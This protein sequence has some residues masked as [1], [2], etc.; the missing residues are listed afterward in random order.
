MSAPDMYGMGL[1]A[2]GGMAG[3]MGINNMPGSQMLL[4]GRG[5]GGYGVGGGY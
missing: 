1:G 3:G 5:G 4:Y 2:M